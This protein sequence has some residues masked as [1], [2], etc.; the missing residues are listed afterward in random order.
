M[1]YDQLCH[2]I[3]NLVQVAEGVVLKS[4]K[5][6]RDLRISLRKDNG[7]PLNVLKRQITDHLCWCE[8]QDAELLLRLME[9]AEALDKLKEEHGVCDLQE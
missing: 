5:K 8:E 9:M 6:R 1:T 2:K 7:R 3:R 4:M